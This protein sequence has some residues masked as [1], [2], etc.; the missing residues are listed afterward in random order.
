MSDD[1]PKINE[2][3]R[4]PPNEPRSWEKREEPSVASEKRWAGLA[5]TFIYSV[6]ITLLVIAIAF[7]VLYVRRQGLGR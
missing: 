5:K 4:R 2:E 6:W 7:V 1:Q 3:R